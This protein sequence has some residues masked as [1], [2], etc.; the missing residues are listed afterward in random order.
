MRR[1]L[2]AYLL[3]YISSGLRSA[4]TRHPKGD[5]GRR[6][7]GHCRKVVSQST[8]WRH[9]RQYGIPGMEWVSET[10]SDSTLNS[11]LDSVPLTS[12]IGPIRKRGHWR[13]VSRE[14][15]ASPLSS[16]RTPERQIAGRCYA[17][18]C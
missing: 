4:N 1:A 12:K 8:A 16:A 17:T 6:I 15:T 9:E 18:A 2:E 5:P 7:C 10:S 3:A 14:S 11:D 13:M